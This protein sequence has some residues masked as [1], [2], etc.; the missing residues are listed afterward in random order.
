MKYDYNKDFCFG[1]GRQIYDA[2]PD[3]YVVLDIETTGLQAKDCEIIEISALR[4]SDN[5]IVDTFN[6]LVKPSEPVPQ[7]ITM[8]TGITNEM[9]EN[10]PDPAKVLSDFYEFIGLTVAV[11]FCVDFD[12]KFLYEHTYRHIRKKLGNSYVDVHNIA[13]KLLQGLKHYNQPSVCEALGIKVTE[14]HRAMADT[15]NCNLAY[16]KL[17]D[18]MLKESFDNVPDNLYRIT[19]EARNKAPFARKNF[20]LMGLN[21]HITKFDLSNL[22]I[23]LGGNI[24]SHLDEPVDVIVCGAQRE[25]FFSSKDFKAAVDLKNTTGNIYILKEKNFVDN[26]IEKNYIKINTGE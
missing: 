16:Q 19:E 1:L 13:K 5:K 3:D 4:V 11:G 6:T 20:Y 12:M 15:T 8:L 7:R 18:M 14:A 2:Y 23:G 21:E 10:A 24:I 17:K 9:L 22:I 26:L 25:D